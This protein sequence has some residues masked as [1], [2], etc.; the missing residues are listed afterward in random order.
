[1]PAKFNYEWPSN[2][3][4]DIFGDDEL[5]KNP[6]K[7]IMPSIEY[8]LFQLGISRDPRY[9]EFIRLR[10]K[11]KLSYNEIGMCVNLTT[12]TIR[13]HMLKAIRYFRSPKISGYIKYGIEGFIK[14][15]IKETIRFSYQ[16][17][18][19]NGVN[20]CKDNN[21]DPDFIKVLLSQDILHLDLSVR[22][23]HCLKRRGV[24]TVQDILKF[25]KDDLLR[26]RNM[27]IKTYNEII[28]KLEEIGV[29]C[30]HL[31]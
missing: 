12:E 28:S 24:C 26:T 5:C 27:G 15:Q 1:M 30:D 21:S 20:D 13:K 25:D 4:Y 8:A 14:H 6:P 19:H 22:A 31:K 16:Q 3:I 11:D 9:V 10:Y 2:L 29:N 18:Y 7:D 17:G 23:Y